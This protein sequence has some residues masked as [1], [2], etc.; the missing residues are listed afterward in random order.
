VVDDQRGTPTWARWLAEAV[1]QIAGQLTR[2]PAGTEAACRR[3]GGVVHLTGGG[4]TTWHAFAQAILAADPCRGEHRVRAVE[5]IAT[6]GYPTPA[7]RPMRSVLDSSLAAQRFGLARTP[8]DI[9]LRR[10]MET[11]LPA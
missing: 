4:D 5:A 3:L 10:A 2:D 7:A 1:A 8:W 9:Q 6:S 11:G